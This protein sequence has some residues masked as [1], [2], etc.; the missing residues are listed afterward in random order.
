[1]YA[2]RS[3]FSSSRT[4]VTKGD[5]YPGFSRD[6]GLLD[7]NLLS[8]GYFAYTWDD[9]NRLVSAMSLIPANGSKRVRNAYDWRSRRVEKS[10]DVW[11]EDASSWIPA[12]TRRYVYDDWNP[13]LET[14]V[15]QDSTNR[16]A[17]LWGPDLSDTLHGAGGVGGLLAVSIDGAYCFPCC[18]ANGNVTAYVAEDGTLA[19]SYTYDA[20]GNAVSAT[21]PLADA[22]THR[23]STKPY[24]PE[25]GLYYYGYRFYSPSL[26]RFLNR[27]PI[28]ESG[29]ENLYA[30]CR[31]NAL[32]EVDSLGLFRLLDETK[33]RYSSEELEKIRQIIENGFKTR[34]E[35][36]RDPFK[37]AIIAN[38]TNM[39]FHLRDNSSSICRFKKNGDPATVRGAT[40]FAGTLRSVK[41]R[42]PGVNGLQTEERFWQTHAYLCVCQISPIE[43]FADVAIHEAAHCVGWG[44]SYQDSEDRKYDNLPPHR[45]D[46]PDQEHWGIP[47]RGYD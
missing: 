39:V 2:G 23:F 8:D 20:F 7:G 13:I 9:D 1:M 12:E 37:S 19:A 16:I 45:E 10:V 11:D 24:D 40:P 42:Y 38:W 41:V 26:G 22:F 4:F 32:S 43:E 5:P 25:F 6:K 28:E 18:D 47:G 14:V 44:S 46:H 3:L 34:I 35:Q 31:N 30:L 27:D 17:Y 36:I 15:T 33:K 29:G 21:G